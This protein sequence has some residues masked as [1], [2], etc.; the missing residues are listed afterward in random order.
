MTANPVWLGLDVGT[1]SVKAILVTSD[2]TVLG[3]GSSPLSSHRD[4]GR[5]EQDPH[6]WISA[7]ASAV[8]EAVA[9]APSSTA[10]RVQGISLCA[11]SGTL[12]VIDPDGV[13]VEAGLMYD[14][15]RGAEFAREAQEAAS[16]TWDRLGYRIQPSWALAKIIWLERHRLLGRGRF[17]AHQSDVVVASMTGTRVATDWSHALKSGYDVGTLAW[18]GDA[19]RALRLREASLPDVVAPGTVLGTTSPA[20]SETVGLPARI[21]IFAGMTDGCAAQ[22]SAGTLNPGDWHSVLG[23]TLVVKTV[24]DHLVKDTTGAIYSHRAPAGDFW[25][26]GGACSVGAGAISSLFGGTDLAAATERITARYDT[27]VDTIPISYPL[28]TRGE[29]FPF[30]APNAEGFL[31]AGGRR[32]PLLDAFG[33]ADPDTVLA[34]LMV[35][36]ALVE[37]LC[38]DTLSS[39]GVPTTGTMTTSGGG[40]RNTWWTQVRADLCGRDIS[41]P[42]TSEGSLGMA[43]LAAWSAEPHTDL[44]QLAGRMSPI[45]SRVHP[46]RDRGLP[47]LYAAFTDELTQTGWLSR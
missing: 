8:H 10:H 11:T 21:P 18:P 38:M 26:P 39:A 14:D 45:G 22:I 33:T 1:Q 25:F 37:R 12:T 36:V 29:R 17:L 27:R 4:H 44:G 15:T 41:I 16:D 2:G 34:S 42:V 9:S 31:L 6:E 43:I 46:G 47:D 23:T 19:V 3:K 24:A 40:A 35:G 30:T 13:P 7:A 20:W 32:R 28:L 5:H